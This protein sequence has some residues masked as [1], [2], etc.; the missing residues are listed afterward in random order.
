ML[1][2]QAD[3]VPL[4][5]QGGGGAAAT[6][7]GRAR[8][9]AARQQGA[10]KEWKEEKRKEGQKTMFFKTKLER[11]FSNSNFCCNSFRFFSN[12]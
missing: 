6:L 12:F 11:V 7:S 9:W 8:E 5:Q 1:S 2:T 10:W 3:S 4:Q